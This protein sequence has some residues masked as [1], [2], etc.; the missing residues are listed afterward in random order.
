MLRDQLIHVFFD[1]ERID[2]RAS[3]RTIN[4]DHE[5]EESSDDLLLHLHHHLAKHRVSLGAVLHDRILLGETA[6]VNAVAQIVHV[7]EVLAPTRIDR[8]EEVEAFRTAHQIGVD[9]SNH[10]LLVLVRRGRIGNGSVDQIVRVDLLDR[11]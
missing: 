2:H 6:Q 3:I 8:L 9:L 7:V 1:R 11:P 10:T 4:F 5:L